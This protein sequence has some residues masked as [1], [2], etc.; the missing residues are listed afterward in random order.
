ML[1]GEAGQPD[2]MMRGFSDDDIVHMAQGGD[3]SAIKEMRA[4]PSLTE[5]FKQLF[6]GETGTE[7]D[8]QPLMERT[9]KSGAPTNPGRRDFLKTVHQFLSTS[10]RLEIEEAISDELNTQGV[11]LPL[12][13]SQMA[14]TPF[15][16]MTPEG[17]Y[18]YT[19]LTRIGAEQGI[20]PESA[21]KEVMAQWE[22]VGKKPAE[23]TI[24]EDGSI[25]GTLEPDQNIDDIPQFARAE[26]DGKKGIRIS[27][28][29][30]RSAKEVTSGYDAPLE[31][32]MIRE[33]MQNALDAVKKQKDQGSIHYALDNDRFTVADNGPGMNRKEIETVFTDLFESGKTSDSGATGGKGIGKA[34]YM[35]GG[36]HF[37]VTSVAMDK[38]TG[39]KTRYTLSGT[40]DE[41]MDFAE[42]H[43]E[44]VADSTPTGVKIM[45]VFAKNQY[46]WRQ[47]EM[48]SKIRAFSRGVQA[49][50]NNKGRDEPFHSGAGDKVIFNNPIQTNKIKMVI[51]LESQPKKGEAVKELRDTI[52]LQ[53]LNNGMYQF[54]EPYY[55]GK[56]TP[57]M[58]ENVLIDITPTVEE[59][60]PEYPFPGP[61]ESVKETL[62][63]AIQKE[64]NE[65]LIH[66]QQE[67]RKNVLKELY[68]SMQ[69]FNS[70][71]NSDQFKRNS[72]LFD[73][74]ER[75]TKAERAHLQM[76]DTMNALMLHTD[77]S[78]DHILS[79]VG[80]EKWIK[81]LE[82]TGVVMDPGMYGVHIPNPTKDTYG[83]KKS[84]ILINYFEHML[85]KD[86]KQAAYEA[87]V[88]MLHEVAHIGEE[89]TSGD[90]SD[91]LNP[92]DLADPN[93]GPYLKTYL[94]QVA[95]QGGIDMGH[96]M[97]FIRRLGLVYAKFGPRR[98]Q[99]IADE[100]E[101]LITD[102]ITGG[103]SKPVQRLLQIYSDSRGRPET[104][105][106][107][108]SGTGTKQA[109]P[110]EPK[111]AVSGPDSGSGTGAIGTLLNKLDELRGDERGS[112][113]LT[114]LRAGLDRVISPKMRES[115]RKVYD[116]L[117]TSGLTVIRNQH[118]ES[119]EKLLIRNRLDG[120]QL[121]G[122][123]NARLKEIVSRL[124]PEELRNYV[125]VRDGKERPMS[126]EVMTA[127][128]EWKKVDDFV[129]QAAKASG[130]GMKRGKRIVPFQEMA[131][132]WAH[133]YPSEFFEAKNKPSAI[134]Q[135][136]NEGYSYQE[137]ER[138]LDRA[139]KYN[140]RLID[141]QHGRVV[142]APGYR[143]DLDVDYQ[144]YND[145]ARRIQ[146]AFDFGPR[147]TADPN[148]PISQLVAMT[149]NPAR[150][151]EILEQYLGRGKASDPNWARVNANL[152]KFQ[153][154]TKLSRF[155]I[156]NTA[157]LGMLPLRA[158][159]GGTAEGIGKV[160]ANYPEARAEAERTGALQSIYNE[161]VKEVGG[162]SGL[163]RWFGIQKS[164][165]LLRTISAIAGKRT[166][167]DLF[168]RLA[169]NPADMR[170]RQ[171]LENLILESPD[172]LL[173]QG[174]LTDKQTNRAGNRM[175]EITQG[176]A[177]NIDLPKMWS[178]DPKMVA[179]MMFKRYAFQQ[180]KNIW[181]AMKQE[182][183][184]KVAIV[185]VGLMEIMGE[186][187]GDANAVLRGTGRT[188][189]KNIAGE[190]SDLGEEIGGA[191]AERG[192]IP[193]AQDVADW[194]ANP[195]KQ[196]AA[197]NL[198]RFVN[199]L[200]QS[201][202]L[203]YL[204]D[205]ASSMRQDKKGLAANLAGPVVGD[206]GETGYNIGTLNGRGLAQQA[207]RMV[208]LFGSGLADSMKA[209][210]EGRQR[211]RA[212]R[213]S[214]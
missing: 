168:Q 52:H 129:T 211:R 86:P 47:T 186:L 115:L 206:I 29:I 56:L 71:W 174:G 122:N 26:Q 97:G 124:S 202:A 184:L 117:A 44:P 130:M 99:A 131:A 146:Q 195:T 116:D 208:P 85:R 107:F 187:T 160:F 141:P 161:V 127:V 25:S 78:L 72:V 51:P 46:N 50:F 98:A 135:I 205:I 43:E 192:Q 57:N 119:L 61:R 11:D 21:L 10:K 55:L 204:G 113:D 80:D 49:K 158:S 109:N 5:K 189:G 19:Y 179:L 136:M 180:S 67:A 155:I 176:R 203:G 104:S 199:N 73:P 165:E 13:L 79:V 42:I 17:R 108:L 8:L 31:S 74:G 15:E 118:G 152:S 159:L 193:T 64:L 87:M 177:S 35:L 105:T 40:P 32:I 213:R 20:T 89:S 4:R 196:G 207:A 103:Y 166:A 22:N 94:S 102:E 23:P 70:G 190:D 24:A 157:N 143:T 27:Q 150:V 169:K 200:S 170:T 16:N 142:N 62:K 148:S 14:E 77:E 194:I 96:Q 138:I 198:E 171:R 132:Y 68:E 137:A 123:I 163:S 133:I 100:V 181:A 106:D 209:T 178:N 18:A 39:Q 88:T 1:K 101:N 30:R 126:A 38:K 3:A 2:P 156:N 90:F 60:D 76:D 69:K 162:P 41:L 153:T 93:I 125:Q 147:D 173:R 214:R 84:T 212:R 164:E 151:A 34:S 112:L 149:D 7:G 114:G 75:L 82:G 92:E 36:N 28:N 185:L 183:P 188:I 12:M 83:N 167:Q 140:E 120:E 121:A 48:L 45:T 134:N 201:W 172:K 81:K 110:V 59:G 33:A 111:S 63:I 58:P 191:I 175:S 128:K 197:D 91:H 144:H 182:H 53:Y 6:S 66:P 9:P 154:F 65:R 139:S 95:T 54:S 37:T 145:M 210:N